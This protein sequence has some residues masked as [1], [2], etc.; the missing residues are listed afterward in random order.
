M[1]SDDSDSFLNEEMEKLKATIEQQEID[2]L[3]TK[4]FLL[5]EKEIIENEDLMKMSDDLRNRKSNEK[6]EMSFE[7]PEIKEFDDFAQNSF[8]KY[9]KNP[10]QEN[11]KISPDKSVQKWLR[12]GH[13]MAKVC[14]ALQIVKEFSD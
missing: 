11:P 7:Y 1:L 13:T 14:F 2:L 8:E 5:P 4:L 10:A 3:P 12:K 9:R 6:A